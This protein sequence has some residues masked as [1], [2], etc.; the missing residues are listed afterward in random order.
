M[1]LSDSMTAKLSALTDR[2]EEV[3]ALLADPEVMGNR[4]QFTALSREFA[5]LEP[6]I[7][8]FKRFEA[9][10]TELDDARSL[11]RDEDHELRELAEEDVHRLNDAIEATERDLRTLL[12]PKDPNDGRNV[13]LEIRAGTGGDEAA[14][15]SGNLFRM[16][17][18]FA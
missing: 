6:L 18:K 12:L 10:S 4:N 8:C 15:F 11:T 1:S 16:Y 2:Y 7:G 3:A 14:I 17:S 5:E 9:L 13:F